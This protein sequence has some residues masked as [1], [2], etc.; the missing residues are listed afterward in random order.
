MDSS[1]RQWYYSA[2][3]A[4]SLLI[5]MGSLTL[6]GLAAL[7]PDDPPQVFCTILSSNCISWSAK[8]QSTVARSSAEAEYRSMAYTAA[9]LTWL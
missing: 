3:I 9:E 4:H 2:G 8:K 5:F 7:L 6:I 1:L